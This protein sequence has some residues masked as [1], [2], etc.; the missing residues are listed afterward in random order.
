MHRDTIQSLATLPRDGPSLAP[1]Y[2]DRGIGGNGGGEEGL[3]RGVW[4]A[5]VCVPRLPGKRQRP[6]AGLARLPPGSS[7][8]RPPAS[9][10]GPAYRPA[11]P[12]TVTA[13]SP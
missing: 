8:P 7:L 11:R 10:P 1:S 6:A 5:G 13:P 3:V 12:A 2:G 9:A 4:G